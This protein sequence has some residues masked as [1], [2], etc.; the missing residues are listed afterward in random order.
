MSDRKVFPITQGVACQLKWTWNTIR[1]QEATSSCCHRVVAVNLD[2]ENFSDI[3]NH[4][5]WVRHREMQLQGLFPQGGCQYCEEIEN[6]GGTS[7]RLLHSTQTG[8]YPP[9]LDLDPLA[10]H[11]TPR[12]L[13]VFINNR[14]NLACIYCD[15]S[16]STRIQ[17]ENSKFGYAISGIDKNLP[18]T[19]NIIPKVALTD[20]YD[21]LL[22]KF[23]LYLE[24]KYQHLRQLNVLGGEP[25]YQKEFFSLTDFLLARKNPELDF[26]VVSNLMVSQP[27]LEEFVDKMKHALV[28]RNLKSLRITA[29]IDCWGLEQEY[30]RYGLDL[31]KWTNNF[32]YLAKHKWIYLTINNTITSLSIKKMPEL[33]NYINGIRKTRQINHSFGLVDGRPHLH[34]EIFGPG[35]F[36]DDFN[37]IISLMNSNTSWDQTTVD[38]MKGISTRLSQTLAD[39]SKQHYLKL[40]L[41]EI[42][43]RRGTDWKSVFPWFSNHYEKDN[44]NVV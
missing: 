2:S 19:K 8:I 30:L 44:N 17:K 15:E 41:D 13:E 14:C 1:L 22:E 10:T 16:N 28:N 18:I 38:Y 12:I 3:H 31:E 6:A 25:F 9:E 35:F 5:T 27:V 24:S 39:K 4:P 37:K 29:S 32:E 34:P 11:V 23:F 40:Y 43:R 42:D 36:T 7:D 33:L 20:N 21:A 26:T